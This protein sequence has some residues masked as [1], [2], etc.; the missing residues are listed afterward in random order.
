MKQKFNFL[1]G[2]HK[3]KMNCFPLFCNKSTIQL[4]CSFRTRRTCLSMESQILFSARNMDNIPHQFR[5]AFLQNDNNLTHIKSTSERLQYIKASWY[6]SKKRFSS[7][8]VKVQTGIQ[9]RCSCWKILQW[10]WIHPNSVKHCQLVQTLGYRSS[11]PQWH[12]HWWLERV[13]WSDV[14][15]STCTPSASNKNRNIC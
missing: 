1:V 8:A 3:S 4:L 12:E 9:L 10:N 11:C 15:M 2:L 13:L 6:V 14:T 5:A 7:G